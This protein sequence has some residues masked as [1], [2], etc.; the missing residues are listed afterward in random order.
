MIYDIYMIYTYIY[1]CLD[2]KVP[3]EIFSNTHLRLVQFLNIFLK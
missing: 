1:I 2:L 3:A